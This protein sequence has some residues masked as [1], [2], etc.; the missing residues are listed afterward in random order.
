LIGGAALIMLSNPNPQIKKRA[1]VF[2]G[3]WLQ[4]GHHA[5]HRFLNMMAA[6]KGG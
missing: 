5:L 2:K 3:Q 4:L 1:Y 6:V